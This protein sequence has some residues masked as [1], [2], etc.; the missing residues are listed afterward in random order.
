MVRIVLISCVSKKLSYESK[1]KD[2]YISPFFKYSLKYAKSLKPNKIF[3]LSAK[4][5][6]LDLRQKVRPYEKTLNNIPQK[7]IKIWA[8]KVI[9]K[10]K[11]VSNLE[12]DKFIFLAGENYRKYLIPYIKKYEVPLKGLTIG[13]QLK[14]LKIQMSKN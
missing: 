11:N 8:N 12:R 2:L 14:Y 5:G 9:S 13:K 1:A 10:L 7:E 6:L 3:I 4:H